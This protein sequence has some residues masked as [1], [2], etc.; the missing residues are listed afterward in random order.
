VEHHALAAAVW[1][2]HGLAVDDL[3]QPT[4][5]NDPQAR[6][7]LDNAADQRN[8]PARSLQA[9]LA[10]T[11][12]WGSTLPRHEHWQ[13]RVAHWHRVVLDHGVDRAIEQLLNTAP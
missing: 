9:L 11:D 1:L 12:F 13:Q 6:W 7:L 8:T 10:R 3:G 5:V 4:P 2:R